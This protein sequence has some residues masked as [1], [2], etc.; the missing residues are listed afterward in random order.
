MSSNVL[1]H[2]TSYAKVV[3]LLQTRLEVIA[4]ME[5]IAIKLLA[6]ERMRGTLKLRSSL[7]T[8]SSIERIPDQENNLC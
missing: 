7:T 5:D 6:G 3:L 2:I 8:C 4:D 1:K